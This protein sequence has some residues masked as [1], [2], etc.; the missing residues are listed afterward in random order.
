[1]ASSTDGR[2]D[3][4]QADWLDRWWRAANYIACAQIFLQDNVL[5]QKPLSALHIKPRLLGHWG[6]SPGLNLLYAHLLRVVRLHGVQALFVAG[7][8]HGAPAVLANVWLEGSYAGVRPELSRNAAGMRRLC[9]E[10]STPG[11]VASHVG[12]HIPGSLHEG[13]ELGYGLLHAF[14]AVFDNPHLLALAV[15][16]DGEAETGPAA[17]AWKSIHFLNPKRDGAVLPVLHLNGYRI[18]APTVFGRMADEHITRYFE[19]LGYRVLRVE[20]RDAAA[21][22]RDLAGAM[23]AAIA[24]IY[25]IQRDWRAP[26]ARERTTPD[27]PLIVLRTPKGWTG[28][29]QVDGLP[30]EGTF[31][32]HQVPLPGARDDATQ[33]AQLD[34]WLRSYRPQELF[35]SSG[36]PERDLLRGLPAQGLL[37]GNCHHADG[38][39]VRIDLQLP[40]LAELA[41][42]LPAPGA[43]TFESARGLGMWLRDT[44]RL[45]AGAANLRIFCPDELVSNRLDAVFETT[46]RCTVQP[47]IPED[48]HLG[49]DGRVLEVLSEHCCEGWLEGYVLSGR[50]GLFACYEAFAPIVD[51]MINQHVKWLKASAEVTWRR[52]LPA[53]NIL[54]TS[55]TW[56]QDHNGY[57]HQG[58][59]FIDN[60]LN[61]KHRHVRVYLA[62]DTNCLLALAQHAFASVDRVNVIIAGK[63]SMP[64]WLSL[65]AALVHCAAGAG[66][67]PWAEG[68][69]ASDP[70]VVLAC[71]GEVPTLE[72]L[73]AAD[74]LRNWVPDLNF[75]LINVVNLLVLTSPLDHPDG[76]PDPDFDALF[77]VERPVLFAFHGYPHVID[78]LVHRRA[79]PQRIRAEGYREEGTTTTPF[80]MVVRNRVSRFHLALQALDLAARDDPA[81]HSLRTHCQQ[82]ITE[83]ALYIRTQ[84][85][86]MPD[87]RDW[88]WAQPPSSAIDGVGQQHPSSKR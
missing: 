61:R 16:G 9:R 63:Q 47:T 41:L 53:L 14:G 24:H 67:W 15:V 69:D 80:D 84:F 33:R 34:A 74:L 42:D 6:T 2:L 79:N 77:T 31:R 10:F 27:W 30:M 1:M 18:A 12:P 21:V 60:V 82:R 39:R 76:L 37:P 48:D 70:E 46:R 52:P 28:P 78:G 5:L 68:G 22:H 87:V 45:N 13:G 38:G 64:Q 59:G 50:H 3:Q 85:E 73:A 66:R 23:D 29:Q 19:G 57:S 8:G 40:P 88:R 17:A 43:T 55:H 54:L 83:H 26:S 49:P 75:R 86:D 58:P 51:S 25:A 71:A 32:A 44:L 4:A 72:M 7:P 35:D 56:R 36:C 20:G 65:Q 11:G 62:P 81:A